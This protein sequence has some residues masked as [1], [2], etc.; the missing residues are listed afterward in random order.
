[1]YEKHEQKLGAIALSTVF[2]MATGITAFAAA[3]W[4]PFSANLPANR[5]DKE[6]SKA[7]RAS[8]NVS[9]FSIMINL[10]SDGYTAVRVWGV[11]SPYEWAVP[12]YDN[13]VPA[14]G[15]NVTLNLDNPVYTSASPT[16]SGKW[17]PN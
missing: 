15:T 5:G 1:M 14:M 17:T 6:V 2:L 13:S 3:A 12:Y 11:T 8:S 4:E 10:I 9:H 7:A 16:V